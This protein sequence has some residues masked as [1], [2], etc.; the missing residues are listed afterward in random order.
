MQKKVYLLGLD[1]NYGKITEVFSPG[2]VEVTEEVAK[3]LKS[4]HYISDYH[5]IG[6][7]FGVPYTE[8]QEKAYAKALEV[9]TEYGREVYNST[10]GS[11]LNIFPKVDFETIFK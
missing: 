5:K 7:R 2:K 10:P 3:L 6:G 8:M 11:K 4:S 1:H 9:Y